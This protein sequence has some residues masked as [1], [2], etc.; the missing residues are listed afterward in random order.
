LVRS[1][2]V[3][4]LLITQEGNLKQICDV[5]IVIPAYNAAGFV[6]PALE[7]IVDQTWWP[8]EVLI[9]DDGSSD[10]TARL[11]KEW[12]ELRSMPF[13]VTL[14]THTNRGA[15]ATRNVGI[16]MAR[17]HWVALMDADDIWESNHLASLLAAAAGCPEAILA[18][19]A[20]KLLEGDQL[21]EHRYDDFWDNPSVRF[22]QPIA[23]T[24][25]LKIDIA[26]FPRLIKGNFI[27]PSS[28]MFARSVALRSGLFDVSLRSGEDREFLVRLLF[29]GPFVYTPTS[30]T[31]YRW[32]DDNLSQLKNAKQNLENGL[33][34][35]EKISNN[36]TLRLTSDQL[37]AC[38]HEIKGAISEY[39]YVCATTNFESYIN[40]RRVVKQLFGPHHMRALLNIKHM[41]HAVLSTWRTRALN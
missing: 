31:Q 5:S 4:L 18:Y 27:K 28:L 14:F 17:S 25:Y 40:A 38:N 11:V 12:I 35:L 32:H 26:V 8:Q 7:S 22:G 6:L 19:G 23:G 16:Q 29:N 2:E 9:I 41:I 20:G 30:I 1:L 3:R 24:S 34:V 15:S 13:V 37:R 36:Q 39:L 33:R 10:A 21:G